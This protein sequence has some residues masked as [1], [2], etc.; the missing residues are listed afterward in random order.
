M[1]LNSIRLYP[2]FAQNSYKLF[3]HAQ[4]N[5]RDERCSSNKMR[6]D[7]MRDDERCRSGEMR[8]CDE[9]R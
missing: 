5:G 3:R 4:Q 1:L 6:Q 2:F 7:V 9:M 8:R